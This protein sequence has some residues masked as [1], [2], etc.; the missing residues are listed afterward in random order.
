[1]EGVV[2]DT[3]DPQQMGRIKIWVPAVDGDLYNIAD[4]PWAGYVSPSAGQTLDYPAGPGN[5]K[6]SGF[7]S[8]GWWSVPK[9]GALV[10]VGF[11]YGDANRR[12]YMGSYFRDHGNRSLP[13]GRNRPDIAK[14]P[15]SDTFEP[16]EPQNSNLAAQFRGAFDTSEAK[17][18]GTYERAV[19]QGKTDKDGTDGYYPD[20]VEPKNAT[21]E[22]QF[23]SQTH[24]LSTPGRHALIFQDHPSNGRIRIKT[25]AGH[26][27]LLD[28]ANE[29]IYIS[30]AKGNSWIELDQDGRIHIYAAD[31]LS[32]STGGDFNLTAVGDIN[33]DS[34][35]DMNIQ[36][37][38]AMKLA[39][40]GVT[41]LSGENLNL[42]SG[43]SFNILAA[44]TILQ[45]GS[46]IHLN[47]NRAGGA[48][49]PTAP[50]I[51]PTHEPWVREVS[52][53]KRGTN[54]KA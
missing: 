22:T 54:W 48:E 44:G 17:T 34:G 46:T 10:I 37:G 30:T 31:S 1:M 2:V 3:S 41:N 19:S 14:T 16:V 51:I 47:G 38:G 33:M 42:E 28:D 53:G 45:T 4:L 40:C 50:T 11:L 52:K 9:S 8:Y 32:V 35:G 29:R 25:A 5:T 26:Q 24:S 39:A 20:L 23:D 18:R 13:T 15:L 43:N 21:G 36:A 49:C 27:V 12:V 6:T 7:M